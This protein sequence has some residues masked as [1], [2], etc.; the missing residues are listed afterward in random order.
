M[1]LE[2]IPQVDRHVSDVFVLNES[3]CYVWKRLLTGVDVGATNDGDPSTLT[4]VEI[5]IERRHD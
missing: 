2:E 3:I 5:E 1:L 4:L